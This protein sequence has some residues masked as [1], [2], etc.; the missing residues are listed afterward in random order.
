MLVD[1][2]NKICWTEQVQFFCKSVKMLSM[3]HIFGTEIC[4]L[5]KIDVTFAYQVIA[6]Q[7]PTGYGPDL[8]I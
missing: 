3:K 5:L 2:I 7:R 4:D 1:T 8:M 6:Y